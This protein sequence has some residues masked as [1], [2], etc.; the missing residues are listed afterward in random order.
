M[1]QPYSTL[2]S[3]PNHDFIAKEKKKKKPG[4]GFNIGSD[5]I[6]CHISLVL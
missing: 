3:G 6:T 1:Y 2:L 4:S 5:C